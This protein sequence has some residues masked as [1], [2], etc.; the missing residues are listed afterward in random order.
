MG[1]RS[2]SR[3]RRGWGGG[4][5]RR[6][7]SRGCVCAITRSPF[8]LPQPACQRTE[9]DALFILSQLLSQSLA[10][11]CSL[12]LR[13]MSNDYSTLPEPEVTHERRI[14]TRAPALA[15]AGRSG[16]REAA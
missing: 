1:V 11:V 7:V 10:I 16:A 4:A 9:H 12:S 2:G 15:A 8:R 14:R 5:A 3:A 6:Q 13:N